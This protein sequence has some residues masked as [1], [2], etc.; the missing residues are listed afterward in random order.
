M[1][2]LLWVGG[3]FLGVLLCWSVAF[4]AKPS[5]AGDPVSS[6]SVSGSQE[7][8]LSDVGARIRHS[9]ARCHGF[10]NPDVLPRPA[11]REVIEK[12]YSFL[13]FEGKSLDGLR[14]EEV[15]AWYELHSRLDS[16]ALRPVSP[17][18]AVGPI[19]FRK[20][21][22]SPPGA[23]PSPAIS[24]LAFVAHEGL[25][26]PTILACDMRHG[27]VFRMTFSKGALNG[28]GP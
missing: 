9:C 15:I 27:R 6:S 5:G 28:K 19:A 14:A 22:F 11:W 8:D 25:K 17:P 10:P 13:G 26:V 3:V 1:K 12:M 7:S 20:H 23:P 4:H 21:G 16:W 2:R 24:H 18:S